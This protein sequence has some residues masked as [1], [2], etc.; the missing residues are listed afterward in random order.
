MSVDESVFVGMALFLI[1]FFVVLGLIAIVASIFCLIG[2]YKFYEKMG[3]PG[4][5]AI[6]PFYNQWVLVEMAGLDPY[7]F[8]LLIAPVVLSI[9]SAILPFIGLLSWVGSL[10]MILAK[11]SIYTNISKML[12]KDTGWIICGVIFGPV[13]LAGAGFS[14]KTEIDKSM[15]FD[16]NGLFASMGNK[17]A[18]SN[19]NTVNT[20]NQNSEDTNK[21]E[22]N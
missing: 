18:N 17:Q 11:I 15:T 5:K 3:V 7:W 16:K 1:I 19:T 6:I 20:D 10:A 12:H 14:N 21:K 22:D 2:T 9:L 4:W 13:M 8:V